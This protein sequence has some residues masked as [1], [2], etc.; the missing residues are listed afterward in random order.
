MTND[1]ADAY[2]YLPKNL[3]G[4]PQ[5]ENEEHNRLVVHFLQTTKNDEEDKIPSN[6][7]VKEQNPQKHLL[8]NYLKCTGSICYTHFLIVQSGFQTL[9]NEYSIPV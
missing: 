8:I 3:N 2:C 6:Y 9:A 1:N 7:L 4:A 5:I